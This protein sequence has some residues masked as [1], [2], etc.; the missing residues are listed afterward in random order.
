MGDNGT[1]VASTRAGGYSGTDK[2][3]EN[4]TG[5]SQNSYRLHSRVH[6]PGK[7]CDERPMSGDCGR[8][9]ERRV[10]REH[11]GRHGRAACWQRVAQKDPEW[12][13]LDRIWEDWHSRENGNSRCWSPCWMMGSPSDEQQG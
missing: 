12:A 13:I 8:D 3:R 2:E 4:L 9:V 11:R 5:C 6:R 10:R 7:G 1:A